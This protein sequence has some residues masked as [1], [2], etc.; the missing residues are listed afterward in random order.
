[1]S[2]PTR[3]VIV[4]TG[5]SSG[6]GRDLAL[7]AKGELVLVARSAEV[8]AALAQEIAAAGGTA[9]V[10]ALDLSDPG[11]T[12]RL[13]DFLAASGLHCEVLVNNAGFGLIGRADGLDRDGQINMLDLNARSLADLTLAVLPGMLH[14]GRGGVLNVASVASFLPGPNM[15]MYYATKAFVRSFSNALWQ[16]CKGRGVTVTALCP[17]PVATAFFTRATGGAAHAKGPKKKIPLI[18]RLIPPTTSRDVALAGWAALAAGK[19]TIIPG[20]ANRVAAAMTRFVP[21]RLLL[22][23]VARFQKARH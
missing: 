18:F 22:A 7:T 14:R 12:A 23:A 15:A 2:A 3:P 11:S 6:I 1:M 13:V 19:H 21:Q 16:E 5:A 4:V 8:L 9:H 17:G 20:P 10:L